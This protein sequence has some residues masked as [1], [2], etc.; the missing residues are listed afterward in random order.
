MHS[1]S[2]AGLFLGAGDEGVARFTTK[3]ASSVGSSPDF[4][5][6]GCPF[7][8]I[9]DFVAEVDWGAGGV[10]LLLPL[11]GGEVHWSEATRGEAGGRCSCG[12]NEL[13]NVASVT[14]SF[15]LS[16]FDPV[17]QGQQLLFIFCHSPWSDGVD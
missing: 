8:S 3:I 6:H 9:V 2:W 13:A 5:C 7:D 4:F 1:I 14:L 10:V 12:R 11:G 17:V 15:L 16:C